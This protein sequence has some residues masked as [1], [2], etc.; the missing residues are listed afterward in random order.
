MNNGSLPP[1]LLTVSADDVGL[2][3]DKFLT[4]QLPELSR[5]RLQSLIASGHIAIAPE[6]R[7]LASTKVM[8]D[9]ILTITIPDVVAANPLPQAIPI[10]I[11]YEDEDLIVINKAAGMVVHPAPGHTND[12]LVNALLSHCGESLSGIGGVRRPGI[13]HR[14]DKDTSGLMVIA[15]NDF[16]HQGLAQQFQGRELSRRYYAY[17]WGEPSQAQGTIDAMIGRSRVNRQKMA[18][19]TK[20]GREA[21]THYETVERFYLES[22]RNCISKID[23]K[24]AT[25]RTHQIRV[26]MHH[27][28]LPVIGD[29]MYG[30]SSNKQA[31]LWP[32]VVSQFSRQAL[33]AYELQFIHPRQNSALKFNC[34][35]PQDLEDLENT[36]K[37]Q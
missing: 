29:P 5:S 35:L 3:L 19:V 8:L 16:T 36:L 15:K 23:C 7:L 24:L 17:V 26:H 12:T 9:D 34:L 28:G 20:N 18:V 31:K 21:I 4:M 14:L 2:R 30:R 11:V 33:H 37:S 13:V 22:E 25:G 10:E 32:A 6:R 1:Y 27:I